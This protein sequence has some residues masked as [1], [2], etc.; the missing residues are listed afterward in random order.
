M[1]IKVQVLCDRCNQPVGDG[2][3]AAVSA[4]GY[5]QTLPT[6]SRRGVEVRSLVG[7]QWGVVLHA[8]DLCEACHALVTQHVAAI[9][10]SQPLAHTPVG[11]AAS[12]AV[13]SNGVPVAKRRGRPPKALVSR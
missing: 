7:D 6:Y 8:E 1:A 9:A 2:T 10:G 3:T 4:V 13:P 11:V 5:G 12:T